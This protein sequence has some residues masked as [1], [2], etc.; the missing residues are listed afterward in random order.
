LL[1]GRLTVS[2]GEVVG[3]GAASFVSGFTDSSDFPFF[4]L[5][6]LFA[7]VLMRLVAFMVS[8]VVPLS[9]TI[10]A[11]AYRECLP[12]T[13]ALAFELAI[14]RREPLP[15]RRSEILHHAALTQLRRCKIDDAAL[16]PARAR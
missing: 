9:L 12:L 13:S 15:R 3:A 16:E 5:L 10:A 4:M 1:K 11:K 8:S 6:D 14:A 7:A 2:V